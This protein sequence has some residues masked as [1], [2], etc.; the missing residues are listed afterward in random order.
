MMSNT[1]ITIQKA[2]QQVISSSDPIHRDTVLQK[3]VNTE[4]R[5]SCTVGKSG[6]FSSHNIHTLK[7]DTNSVHVSESQKDENNTA[8]AAAHS[9]ASTECQIFILF[10]QNKGDRESEHRRQSVSWWYTQFVASNCSVPSIYKV[11]ACGGRHIM[12]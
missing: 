1:A 6:H 4:K 11:M 10:F 12:D 2:N 7:E 5:E 8:R 3:I 9:V